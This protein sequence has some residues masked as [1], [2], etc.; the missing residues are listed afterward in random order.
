[1]NGENREHA[2][3][4]FQGTGMLPYSLA[5]TRP[6]EGKSALSEL[7]SH[8]LAWVSLKEKG[9]SGIFPCFEEQFPI[10]RR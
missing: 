5:M 2:F 9:K 6:L 1:M 3:S 8:G 10:R 4:F 7:H